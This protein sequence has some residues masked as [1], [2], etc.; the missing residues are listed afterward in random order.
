M[1]AQRFI[2]CFRFLSILGTLISFQAFSQSNLDCKDVP[3]ESLSY[4]LDTLPVD[5]LSLKIPE[6]LAFSLD[7][8][9]RIIRFNNP[10]EK[11]TEVCYRR[12]SPQLMEKKYNRKLSFYEHRSP[13]I[14]SKSF[15]RKIQEQSIFSTP[16]LY[17]SGTISRGITVGN[18]QSLFVNSSLNLQLNGKLSDDL[19]I[20]AVITDQNVPYQPEGNTQQI[21]DFDN[22]YIELYNENLNVLAGDIVLKNPERNRFLHY[23]KNQQGLQLGYQNEIGSNW[24]STTKVSAAFAKGKFASIRLDPIEGVNGPYRLRG[25]QN[26]RFIIVLA[27]SEKVYIDGVLLK[28]GFDQ[29]YVIDYNLG[30]ITFNPNVVITRFTRIRVDFEYSEQNY[31]RSNML[32]SQ[33]LSSSRLTLYGEFYREKDNPQS[34]FGFDLNEGDLSTLSSIGDNLDQALISGVDTVNFSEDRILYQSKDTVVNGTTYSIYEY[35]PR[36]SENLVSVVFTEVGQ[37]NGNYRLL[38]TTANGRIYEWIAPVDGEL[39]GN[40]TP[41]IPITTPNLR[42]MAIFGSEVKLSAHEIFFQELAV[43]TQD[44]N[45]YSD[46]DD[47]NNQGLAWKGGF[48]T[49][50]R[51]I[52]L[53]PEYHLSSE[54]SFEYNEA[55]FLPIDRFRYIEFNRDWNY[56]SPYDSVAR[57]ERIFHA[58]VTVEKGSQNRINYEV[59]KRR[60]GIALSG[61][62][63]RLAVEKDIGPFHYSGNHFLM[64]NSQIYSEASWRRSFSTLSIDVDPFSFGA[65]YNL[66]QNLI[67][68]SETDSVINSAMYFS[69][70]GVIIRNSDSANFNLETRLGQRNDQHPV[71]GSMQDFTSSDFAS[72]TFSLP[73]QNN[74]RIRLNAVYRKIDDFQEKENSRRIIQGKVIADNVLWDGVVRSSL[75]YGTAN[76]RELRREYVFTQVGSG[77]GTHTWRDENKDGIQDLNEFYEAINPDERNY[78]KLFLPTDEYIEAFQTQYN[79]TINIKAPSGWRSQGGLLGYLYKVTLFANWNINR[80]TTSTKAADKVNPFK[81]LKKEKILFDRSIRRYNFFYN[82]SGTGIGVEVGYEDRSNKQ[83]NQNG[84]ES[85]ENDQFRTLVRWNINRSFQSVM[86]WENETRENASDFLTSRNFLLE[87]NSYAP[88]FIWQPSSNWRFSVDY[89]YSIRQNVLSEGQG[90][91]SSINE[92][93]GSFTWSNAQKGSLKADFNYLNIDFKGDEDTYLGYTLLDGL[94]EGNNLRFSMNW[95]QNLKNGLQL[96]VQYFGRKSER[97]EVVHS[98]TVQLTAFF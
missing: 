22:V 73:S 59:D 58:D 84:F 63:Q 94:Q 31:S 82:R 15:S 90:E 87:G 37:G 35:Q 23:Y 83:L 76:A 62:Q 7:S 85:M 21:R 81:T 10:L 92:W 54:I 51:N 77:Q 3:K 89:Q 97:T 1:R 36:Q 53:F 27:N 67:R 79:H 71:S 26:E 52:K 75:N 86:K 57:F 16:G 95:Q 91:K 98:G 32:V 4:V 5:P 61:V 78:I 96:T 46:L 20:R 45:L 41:S 56:P 60:R 50:E 25:A 49:V 74:Q 69:E 28:R 64:S 39:Q 80:K 17:K 65:F 93:G 88:E 38:N 29:D 2:L 30:E 13:G 47:A 42:Q 33:T 9:H 18:R 48:R 55:D 19:N 68:T 12:V 44:Q 11:T 40:F 8:T 34:N 14:S 70:G 6:G 72:L 66:D 43:S 24:E